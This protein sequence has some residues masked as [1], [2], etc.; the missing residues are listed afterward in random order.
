[1][2]QDLI[3]NDDNQRFTLWIAYALFGAGILFGGLPAIAGV[4]LAYIKK[5]EVF[6]AYQDH[7]H[8]LIRTFW[9]TLLGFVLGGILTIIGI[10]AL[11]IFAVFIW[12]IFRVVVGALRLKENAT[13]TPTGWF[14]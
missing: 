13:I 14:K 12:Y 8:F 10:G 5:G 11:I 3:L 7:Y 9:G 6:G 1:M 4:I 2:N